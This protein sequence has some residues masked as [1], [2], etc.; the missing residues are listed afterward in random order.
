MWFVQWIYLS[1]VLELINGTYNW[2]NWCIAF[3]T[4]IIWTI[5]LKRSV[6]VLHWIWNHSGYIGTFGSIIMGPSGHSSWDLR[7]NHIGTYES[8]HNKTFGSITMGPTG[9]IILGPPDQSYWDLG[10]KSQ[11]ALWVNHI[12][13]LKISGRY[14]T[15]FVTE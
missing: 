4:G 2:C 8:S 15:W 7:V 12:G 6:T 11:W 10:V 5:W 9:Q 1:I 14:Q 13:I 3:G